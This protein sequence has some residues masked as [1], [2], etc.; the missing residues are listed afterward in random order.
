[1]LHY[2]VSLSLISSCLPLFSTEPG[3]GKT[4]IS[5]HS[6]YTLMLYLAQ[7]IAIV[8]TEIWFFK[9]L[10]F[11]PYRHTEHRWQKS[12]LINWSFPSFSDCSDCP[13]IGARIHVPEGDYFTEFSLNSTHKSSEPTKDTRSLVPKHMS[14]DINGR[15]L[16]SFSETVLNS[17]FWFYKTKNPMIKI[18]KT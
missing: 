1:M 3:L 18:W 16:I 13:E 4:L 2:C 6:S 9:N 5:M 15:T 17:C 11:C 12:G 7:L 14:T 10:A 8:R